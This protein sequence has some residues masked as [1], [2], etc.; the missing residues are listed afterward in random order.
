MSNVV[1]LERQRIIRKIADVIRQIRDERNHEDPERIAEQVF[2]EAAEMLNEALERVSI[3]GQRPMSE[4]KPFEV[5]GDE[6]AE[7]DAKTRR[8]GKALVVSF[9]GR[10][11]A[12]VSD[13]GSVLR[14]IL[15]ENGAGFDESGGFDLE[16]A[17]V[18]CAI[19]DGLYY[20]E[21]ELVDDGPGDWPGGREVAAQVWFQRE[22]TSKEWEDHC[23][24]LWPWDRSLG[25]DD[26]T[27]E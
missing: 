19:P 6:E 15:G 9:F 16:R 4:F 13:L 3:P 14:N 23:E 25:S 17:Q 21:I 18:R 11:V 7:E 22:A 24:G 1:D 26:P 20:V 8:E 2:E 12:V 10:A 27:T 5:E